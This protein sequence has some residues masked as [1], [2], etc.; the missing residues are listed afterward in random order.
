MNAELAAL[1]EADQ[2]DRRDGLPYRDRDRARLARVKELVAEGQVITPDDQFRAAMILHHGQT[3]E[4]FEQAHRFARLAFESGYERAR[5]LVALTWD[6]WLT[7]QGRP[8]KFGTQYLHDRSGWRLME[9]DPA[10][11]DAERAEWEVPPLRELLETVE[12]LNRSHR[13]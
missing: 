5:K 1:Y 3:L 6:R 7:H 4:D 13:R 8:Q 11:T 2:A 9:Y 12:Q 10:T